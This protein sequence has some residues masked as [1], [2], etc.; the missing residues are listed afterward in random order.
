MRFSMFMSALTFCGIAAAQSPATPP[1]TG[2]QATT[3]SASA[4]TDIATH[5]SVSLVPN[6]LYMCA[7]ETN[8]P[9]YK[10][11]ATTGAATEIGSMDL[12]Q[13]CTDLAFRK[14][15]ASGTQLF[16]TSFTKAFLIDPTTGKAKLLPNAYGTGINDINALVAEP[17]TGILYAAGS[18][19]P[20]RFISISP[21]TGKA[22]VLGSLGKDIGSA[23]DLE[24]LNGE[25]YGLVNKSSTGTETYLATI[26][27]SAGTMG[28][29][30]D[31][32]PI[33][34]KVDGKL[35]AQDNVW[36]LANREGVLF[37]VMESG[38]VLI[39]DPA[40]GVGTL[41]GDNYVQQAGLAVSP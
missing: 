9:L 8:S 21:T 11:S 5:P 14:T 25:L 4:T 17:G 1:L 28:K 32:R 23:G 18:A 39:I 15:K 31:L 16:G 12:D 3:S 34:L 26:S 10:L 6:T 37:A 19:A 35:E 27:L 2:P 22:T 36:G 30:T 33:T 29:A 38:D 24:F 13:T 41:K 40:T 20:G 7:Y